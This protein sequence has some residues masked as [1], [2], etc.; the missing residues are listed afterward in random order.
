MPNQVQNPNPQKKYDLQERT[1]RFGETIIGFVYG[2][3]ENPVNK[4]LISQLV[5]S[6]SSV[7]A[8]YMEADGASS[9]KDFLNKISLCNK[10]AKETMHW[11]RMIAVANPSKKEICRNLWR[12][13]HELSLIFSTIAKNK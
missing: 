2:L 10:E 12:E 1:G 13:A 3:P 7:G 5:R 11:L 6:A 4:P 8:N 9:K